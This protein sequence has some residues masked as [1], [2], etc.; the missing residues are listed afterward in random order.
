MRAM[1]AL[2]RSLQ[3]PGLELDRAVLSTFC[4]RRG[5]R[6]LSLFGS[7]L[8]GLQGA[9]SDADL[10]VEFQSGR[11]PTLLD[12]VEMEHELSGLLGGLRIDLRTPNDLSRYFRDDV[13][14]HAS[15]QYDA[16]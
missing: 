12:M 3:A 10:L 9:A 5:I 4:R 7:R 16:G 2:D 13:L 15:V 1:A 14:R 6:R 11:V 8:R